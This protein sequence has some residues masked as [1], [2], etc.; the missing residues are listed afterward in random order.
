MSIISLLL[1]TL[2]TAFAV[3]VQLSQ[4]GR[5][6]DANGAGINGAQ[7]MTF[8]LYD[9]PIG[10]MTLWEE[11][12]QINFDNGYYAALLGA[13]IVSNPL[14]DSILSDTPIYLE[15]E[16]GSSGPIGLRQEVVSAPYARMAG[17]ATHL[18]GGTVDATNVSVDGQLVIDATGSW[19]GPAMTISWAD[20]QGIPSDLSDGD[21]DTLA[22]ITCATGE[23]LG[24]NGNQWACAAD[25]G[26]TEA[27]VEDFV[28]N[29]A[30]DLHANTTIGGL[31]ILTEG[32]ANTLI[33]LLPRR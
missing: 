27:E 3:P 9:S 13:N 12:L 18:S 31:P 32:H 6:L 33:D 19:V 8:R 21:D 1:G 10:G 14:N 30:L 22:G 20:I 2:S 23:I 16:I 4:H 11:P 24:W 7:I 28:T 5:L 26:L 17:T 25:N 15:V 29:G